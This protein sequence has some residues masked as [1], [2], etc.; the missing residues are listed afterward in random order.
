[1]LGLDFSSYWNCRGGSGEEALTMELG[2]QPSRF[3][4]KI[5]CD[6]GVTVIETATV[7]NSRASYEQHIKKS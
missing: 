4:W 3:Q 1:M 6:L 7:T 5:A 2:P